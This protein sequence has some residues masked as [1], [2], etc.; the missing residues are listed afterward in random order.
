MVGH[1]DSD[2]RH[3]QLRLE[4]YGNE[5][6]KHKKYRYCDSEAKQ[7]KLAATSFVKGCT[8]VITSKGTTKA[9][10]ALL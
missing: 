5:C 8:E 10:S 7:K 2:K 4:D 6:R 9:R 1:D 3:Y